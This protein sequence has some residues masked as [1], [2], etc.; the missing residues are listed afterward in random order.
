MGRMFGGASTH[1]IVLLD[2]SFSMSDH[3]ADT[4]AFEQAKGVVARLAAG[5]EQQD[6]PQVFTLLRFSRA[7]QMSRGTQPDLLEEPLDADFSAKLE[8]VLGPVQP[9]ETDAGP[10]DALEAVGRLPAKGDDEDRIVYLV[11]DFRA[12]QWQEPVA[13]RKA[14]ERLNGKGMQV[15]LINCVDKV[16]Q[17]LAIAG[18]RPGAGTRAAGV[19]LL[20]EVTVRN[21]GP[22]DARAVSVSLRRRRPRAAAGRLRGDSGRQDGHAAFS[23]AVRHRRRARAG[24][25]TGNRRR[26]RRQQPFAGG[27][28]SQGGGRVDDRRRCPRA[29]T[30][31]FWPRRRRPAAK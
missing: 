11:S 27:R 8:K 2:D 31:S 19:P 22:N 10:E 13:L 26:G 18:L 15:H 4:T 20:V 23:G 25:P 6:T 7:R 17:N 5:A 29:P 24:G 14:L 9:S 1:H 3:W 12:N 30:R 21:F 16:H 28:R